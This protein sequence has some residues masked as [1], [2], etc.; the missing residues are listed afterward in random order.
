MTWEIEF[1]NESVKEETLSLSPK[2]LAKVLHIFE[3]IEIAG[4]Q[5]GEPTL[6]L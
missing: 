6:N 1:F 4:A 5:L 3:M 2:I